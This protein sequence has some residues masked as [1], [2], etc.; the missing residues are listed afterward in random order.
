MILAYLLLFFKL[1]NLHK[2]GYN[3]YKAS[4]WLPRLSKPAH[5][6]SRYFI[7]NG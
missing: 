4:I 3:Y 7:D 6:S 5:T 1:Y 2:I